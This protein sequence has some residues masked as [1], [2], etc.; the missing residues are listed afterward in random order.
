MSSSHSLHDFVLL[1]PLQESSCS[2]CQRKLINKYKNNSNI[3][4][5]IFKN[6]NNTNN[7]FVTELKTQNILL[8]IFVVPLLISTTVT[9]IPT[10]TKITKINSS[11]SK[12]TKSR[13]NS[14]DHLVTSSSLHCLENTITTTTRHIDVQQT[15][16]TTLLLRTLTGSPIQQQQLI[17]KNIFIFQ[18][19]LN[20]TLILNFIKILNQLLTVAVVREE[21]YHISKGNRK[22]Y[23][24][25]IFKK[26]TLSL[27]KRK[28]SRAVS[29]LHPEEAFKYRILNSTAISVSRN[30]CNASIRDTLFIC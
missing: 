8:W 4:Y 10:L 12:K 28:D 1:L 11:A 2:N 3:G 21:L 25:Y 22:R 17:K 16:S 5:N 9:L 20:I 18:E 13:E 23:S 27:I 26:T 6:K 30:I 19:L 14:E 24:F 7:K 15:R 29:I